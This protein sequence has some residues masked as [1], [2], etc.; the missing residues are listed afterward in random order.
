MN[1]AKK[2]LIVGLGRFGN[3][4]AETMWER[5]A[6]VTVVDTD[7]SLVDAVKARVH[8]AFVADGT[9]VTVLESVGARNMDAAVVTFGEAFES[10]VLAVST[11]KSLAVPEIVARGATSRR[12]EVL[13][14]VGAT[15]IVEVEHEMGVRVAQQLLMPSATEFI[16]LASQY[17][18]V[19]WLVKGALVG[20]SLRESGFRQNYGINVIGVRR[21]GDKNAQLKTPPPDYV[22]AAGDVCLLVAEDSVMQR[23]VAEFER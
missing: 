9:D 23:F 3:A 2:V 6:D 5:G 10:A 15:R 7:S 12:V 4:V 17:R 13:R 20:R 16:D 1:R 11:L 18:V 14:A 22:L 21:S 8:A 19:P